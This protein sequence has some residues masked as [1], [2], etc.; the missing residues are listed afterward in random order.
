ML[1]LKNLGIEINYVYSLK[2]KN[3]ARCP[4]QYVGKDLNGNFYLIVC[5]KTETQLF[6]C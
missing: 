5:A 2:Y 6:L 3:T 4:E 1:I